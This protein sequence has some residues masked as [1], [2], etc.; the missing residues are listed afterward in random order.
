MVVMHGVVAGTARVDNDTD[1]LLKPL[2]SS[3]RCRSSCGTSDPLKTFG[4]NLRSV[5]SLNSMTSICKVVFS[6]TAL[7]PSL[8]GLT[9]FLK[10]EV[11]VNENVFLGP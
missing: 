7:N 1:G 2:S 4:Y 6:G 5:N 3:R 10:S 11:V 8:V 9:S